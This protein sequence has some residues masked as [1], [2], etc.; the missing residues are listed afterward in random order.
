MPRE[1]RYWWSEH[2]PLGNAGLSYGYRRLKFKQ[3]TVY[4]GTLYDSYIDESEQEIDICDSNYSNFGFSKKKLIK[5][6]ILCCDRRKLK[7]TK[8]YL[9]TL[10]FYNRT[11]ECGTINALTRFF[12]AFHVKTF[13]AMQKNGFLPKP[14][15]TYGKQKLYFFEHLQ[16]FAKIYN[17]LILQGV[18]HPTKEKYPLHYAWLLKEWERATKKI[19]DKPTDEELEV[20][21]K[22]PE[23][24]L[25]KVM[26]D[27]VWD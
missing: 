15:I 19:Y 16:A 21:K 24:E 25:I 3:T 4:C 9:T 20:V 14:N 13:L 18:F 1:P 22:V 17:D 6:Q 27:V 26:R 11:V 23:A 12:P 8:M 5:D 7:Q 10:K 2:L